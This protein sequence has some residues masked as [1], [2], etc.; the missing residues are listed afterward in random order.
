MLASV[1]V[2]R[3]HVS[4][5]DPSRKRGGTIFATVAGAA[6]ITKLLLLL[7]C[8]RSRFPLGQFVSVREYGCFCLE[9]LGNYVFGRKNK[10][11]ETIS[12]SMHSLPKGH[13]QTYAL[14]NES[15]LKQTLSF[16]G[17]WNFVLFMFQHLEI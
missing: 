11:L 2:T 1:G 15:K 13:K 17:Q 6:V 7:F 4:R 10:V 14:Q 12:A 5:A 16:K 8:N 3:V 9:N